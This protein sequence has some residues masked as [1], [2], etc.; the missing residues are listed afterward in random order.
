MSAASKAYL[1][2]PTNR[3][4]SMIPGDFGKP[5]IGQTFEFIDD[6]VKQMLGNYNKYGPVFRLSLAFQNIVATVGPEFVRQVT[7][8]Q[9]KVFSSQAGW[10][11]MVGECLLVRT[12]VD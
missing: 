3:D 12:L 7:L 11:D 6:N 9:D 1:S 8:D 10:E 5:L 2:E 4:L